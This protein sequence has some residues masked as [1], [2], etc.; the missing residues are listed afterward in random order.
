M[1][2]SFCCFVCS[3][4]FCQPVT[5]PDVS[6][7]IAMIPGTDVPRASNK[8]DQTQHETNSDEIDYLLVTALADPGHRFFILKLDLELANFMKDSKFVSLCLLAL[9]LL[10]YFLLPQYPIVTVPT[11]EHLPKIDCTSHCKLF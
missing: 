6:E 7:T 3:F 11:N 1:E 8:E 9:P 10:N 5:N 2:R 4:R